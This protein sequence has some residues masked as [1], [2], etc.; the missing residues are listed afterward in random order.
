MRG[1]PRRR[2]GRPGG[3]GRLRRRNPG[4]FRGICPEV[5]T[6]A[7]GGE[8][9]VWKGLHL[10]GLGNYYTPEF[11]LFAVPERIGRLRLVDRG[12]ANRVRERNLSVQVWTVNETEEMERLIDLGVNG[13]L[14]DRPV[15]LLELLR[16]KGLR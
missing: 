1:N 4:V 13:I 9:I 8:V 14:T 16:E 3:G 12:F 5:A 6:A 11:A 10:L 2:D 7:A 15:H